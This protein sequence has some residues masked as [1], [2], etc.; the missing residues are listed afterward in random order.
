MTIPPTEN[1]ARPSISG[2]NLLGR[3]EA[4]SVHFH[5]GSRTSKGAEHVIN[6]RRYDAEMHIVHKN[7]K[8]DTIAEATAHKD[9]L[10]VLGIMINIGRN[11]DRIYPALDNIFNMVPDVTK[12]QSTAPLS[13]RITLSHF[14][15]D[16]NTNEFFTYQGSLTTPDC[17]EAVTWTVF[18]QPLYI[19]L[20]QMQKLWSVRDINGEVMIDNYRPVQPTNG[21]VVLYRR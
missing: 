13:L 16:L 18:P 4:M 5:W 12:Y 2:G 3:F 6:G 7:V 1:G 19:T 21:R 20:E 14:L 10:A 9:G 8:Y 17:S 15:G 11:I